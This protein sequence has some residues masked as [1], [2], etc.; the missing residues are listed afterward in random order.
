MDTG[1]AVKPQAALGAS[2][3]LT[4]SRDLKH[5]LDEADESVKSVQAETQVDEFF[6]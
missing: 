4:L 1:C 2:A 3:L 6:I 5:G